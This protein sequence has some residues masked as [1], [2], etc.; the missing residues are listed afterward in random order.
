M[1]ATFLLGPFASLALGCAECTVAREVDLGWGV[2]ALLE[3]RSYAPVAG[4]VGLT[5]TSLGIRMGDQWYIRRYIGQDGEQCGGDAPMWVRFHVE[6]M[7]ATQALPGGP[8]ELLMR[9]VTGADGI[10]QHETLV[11]GLGPAGRPSCQGVFI[12]TRE[13]AWTREVV[14]GS[15]AV[16]NG[17]YRSELRFP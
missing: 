9:W 13:G 11:C 6:E 3:D 1:D 12:G 14:V 8:N 10:R 16:Q 15:G 4:A 2:A 5:L 7:A 17:S